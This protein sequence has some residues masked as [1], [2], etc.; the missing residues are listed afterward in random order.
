LSLRWSECL[1]W[2][3][4]TGKVDAMPLAQDRNVTYRPRKYHHKFCYAI[5]LFFV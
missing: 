1:P 2:C 4:S 5:V 3:E